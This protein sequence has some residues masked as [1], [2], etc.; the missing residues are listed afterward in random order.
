MHDFNC[1]KC[2]LNF[3]DLVIPDTTVQ[4]PQ[5]GDT[6]SVRKIPSTFGSYIIKG[7]NSGSTRRKSNVKGVGSK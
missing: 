7:D 1:E 2:E 6:A 3:E 5:C 4:C